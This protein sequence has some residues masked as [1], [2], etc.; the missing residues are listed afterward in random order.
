MNIPTKETFLL[1]AKATRIKPRLIKELRFTPEDITYPETR[2]MLAITTR[3]GQE[4]VLL[5]ELPHAEYSTLIP[6][7]LSNRIT[8]SRTG[9]SRSIT[10]DLCYTWQAGSNAARI[11][12]E[13][14]SH[15]ASFTL[16]VCADLNCSLHVRGLTP[17]AALSR[18]QLREDITTVQRIARLHEKLSAFLKTLSI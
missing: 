16:L 8:D 14:A 9:R 5:V 4:G 2:E 13:R 10:C 1:Q 18:T 17:Q 3:S 7:I 6:F 15:K 11:S 12:C